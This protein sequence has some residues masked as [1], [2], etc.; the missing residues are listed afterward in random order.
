LVA[1]NSTNS[2]LLVRQIFNQVD[3]ISIRDRDFELNTKLSI[4][5]SKNFKK[6]FTSK[7]KELKISNSKL[8]RNIIYSILG[9]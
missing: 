4:N 1:E 2:S 3:L 6:D 8:L 7:A 9:K 5:V